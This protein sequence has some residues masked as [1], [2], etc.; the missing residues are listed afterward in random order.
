MQTTYRVSHL[1][2]ARQVATSLNIARRKTD[3]LD[4]SSDQLT[5]LLDRS[6]DVAG[7]IRA[8]T[9]VTPLSGQGVEL[10]HNGLTGV[11]GIGSIASYDRTNAAW[12][13]LNIGGSSIAMQVAGVT[14]ATVDGASINLASGMVLKVDS[15][16]VV[17]PRQTGWVA[18]TGTA[19]TTAHATYTA[20]TTLTFSATYT[21]SELT[22]L[23]TRLAAVETALQGA[24]RA[25]KSVKDALI[26]HGLIGT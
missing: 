19:E 5:V 3:A 8:T 12:Q 4:L 22:A 11:D 10:F 1:S 21:Q 25:Q 15:I 9:G 17:G 13:A 24:T 6:Q 18:D 26:T 16:Q 20:G 7:T 2:D 14:T 23:A